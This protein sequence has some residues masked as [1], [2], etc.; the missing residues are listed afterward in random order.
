[1]RARLQRH[2]QR[3]PARGLAR[4]LERLDLGMGTP[5]WLGPAAP[6]YH[7]IFHNHRTDGGIGPGAALP[8]PAQRQRQRHEALVGSFRCFGFFSVLIFQDAE[9]HLRISAGRSSSPESSPSTVSKSLASRKL[10]YTE[11]KR[12]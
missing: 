3:G 11:A 12:T 6:D 5:A 7:A 4:A 1:M 9:D 10:R 2:I 8:A